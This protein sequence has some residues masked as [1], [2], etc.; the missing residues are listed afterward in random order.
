[1]G[2]AGLENNVFGFAKNSPFLNF[3]LEALREN[4][5][6]Y[7]VVHSESEIHEILSKLCEEF[8][9]R[10]TLLRR[11]SELERSKMT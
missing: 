2:T 3:T 1:M 7:S 6:R 11:N 8:R 9:V 10:K 4:Y 5:P